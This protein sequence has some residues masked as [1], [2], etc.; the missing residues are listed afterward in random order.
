MVYEEFKR[1]LGKAALTTREFAEL[2]KLNPNSITNYSKRGT[3]PNNLAVIAVLM[4]VMADNGIDFR[5]V[6]T[7]IDI[8]PNKVRGAA[9]KGKFGGDKQT[10]LTIN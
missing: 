5:P 9:A 6:V 10:S 3:V 2:L 1:Q 4:G 8:E 7:D